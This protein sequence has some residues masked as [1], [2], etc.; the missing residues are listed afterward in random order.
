MNEQIRAAA[1]A[2]ARGEILLPGKSKMCLSLVRR[3]VEAG[4]FG[5]RVQFYDTY[6][7]AETSRRT[8]KDVGNARADPWAADVEASMKYLGFAV[9][10]AERRY[11]DLVF[12]NAAAKPYGHVGLLY[13]VN[14]VL[15]NA[16]GGRPHSVLLAPYTYLTPLEHWPLTLVARLQERN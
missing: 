6:L 16:P 13:D 14:T 11:G 3:V 7:A 4:L 5:G 12:N 15:E 1:Y 2:A 9:P 10:F 8:G